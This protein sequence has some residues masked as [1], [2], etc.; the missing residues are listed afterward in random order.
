MWRMHLSY[1]IFVLTKRAAVVD[2]LYLCCLTVEY[3][4][5]KPLVEMV[6]H[7]SFLQFVSNPIA[8][9]QHLLFNTCAPS[10]DMETLLL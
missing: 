6:L 10:R 7:L 9:L 3:L 4:N 2:C 1:L 8:V 5:D